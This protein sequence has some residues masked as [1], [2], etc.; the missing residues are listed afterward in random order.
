MTKT[1]YL[2]AAWLDEVSPDPADSPDDFLHSVDGKW[3]LWPTDEDQEERKVWSTGIVDGAV[4]EFSEYV[5]HGHWN[6]TILEAR[7]QFG[8]PVVIGDATIP[9]E[10]NCFYCS[11]IDED[12]FET[13]SGLVDALAQNDHDVSGEIRVWAYQWSAGHHWAFTALDGKGSFTR[14]E[15]AS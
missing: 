9:P 11:D 2:P 15:L 14:V 6:L 8:R 12:I 10:A 4:V 5:D 7:N 1:Q 13:V 3:F